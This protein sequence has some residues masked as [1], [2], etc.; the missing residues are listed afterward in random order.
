VLKELEKER[1]NQLED[2]L[3]A[4]ISRCSHAQSSRK[5]RNKFPD[6]LTKLNQEDWVLKELQE[7]E[8]FSVSQRLKDKNQ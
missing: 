1:E 8:N 5:V 4:Q 2:A 3:L 7:S 6:L